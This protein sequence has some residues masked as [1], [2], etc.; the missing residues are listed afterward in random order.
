MRLYGN[1]VTLTATYVP[2]GSGHGAF[3]LTLRNAVGNDTVW[4]SNDGVTAIGFLLAGEAKTF[5]SMAIASVYV[6]GT[7][8][9]FLYWD[10]E[11]TQ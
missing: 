6:K 1:K 3:H 5:Y 7:A 8:G 4:I 2:L 9:Q 10:G 11:G